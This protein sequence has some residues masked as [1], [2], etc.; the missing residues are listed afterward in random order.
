MSELATQALRASVFY[1]IELRL[2]YDTAMQYGQY[3]ITTHL[4][5]LARQP[6][7]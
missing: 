6:Y 2:N 5:P 3:P 4:G 1:V 7:T